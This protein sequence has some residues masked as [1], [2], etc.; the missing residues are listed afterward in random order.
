MLVLVL[1]RLNL[2]CITQDKCNK[3]MNK[4]N[5]SLDTEADDESFRLGL[6]LFFRNFCGKKGEK[7]LFVPEMV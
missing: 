4:R 1:N 2:K 7:N 5:K 6:V 3:N